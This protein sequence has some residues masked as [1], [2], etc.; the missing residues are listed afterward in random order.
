M[1]SASLNIGL[2]TYGLDR[3][4][5]GIGRYTVELLRAMEDLGADLRCVLF[6]TGQPKYLP[7]EVH[8][9]RCS[10]SAIGRLPN[11]LLLSLLNAW[12]VADKLGLQI[13]HDPTGIAPFSLRKRQIRSVVTVHD[14]YPFLFPTSSTV[15]ENLI[16]RIWLPIALSHI[17]IIITGSI[18]SKRDIIRYL[19]QPEEKIRVVP[20]GVSSRFSQLAKQNMEDVLERYV[21]K[22]GFI[23]TVSSFNPRRN[24]KRLLEAYRQL[25]TKDSFPPLIIIG[26]ARRGEIAEVKLNSASDR[27]RWLGYVPDEDLPALYN[28]AGMFI[29]PSLYEGFGLPPL[30]AFACGAPVACS[31]VPSLKELVGNAAILFD[32][33]E[34]TAIAA[35]ISRLLEDA[36]LR[37]Q[38]V[39][40]GLRRA[41][42]F[43][44][45][46]TA[47]M[48]VDAYRAVLENANVA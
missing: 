45:L 36:D 6:T 44:W 16:A 37:K 9:D 31:Q 23:L 14:T 40:R 10:I 4:L 29:F 12:R 38:L 35:S 46:R 41:G 24:I 5:T 1:K 32:P 17:D 43:T 48:T 22:P 34:T 47:E 18:N 2:L 13:L 20:C 21:L 11:V 19:R 15:L 30:E 3:P 27:V 42:E 8:F 33:F 28:G 26:K 39:D 25:A 7:A